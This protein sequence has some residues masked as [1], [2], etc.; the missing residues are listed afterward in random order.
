[1]KT[2]IIS[3]ALATLI[4][5][6]GTNVWVA[7][8][9]IHAKSYLTLENIEAHAEGNN[10]A[11]I[12][13]AIIVAGVIKTVADLAIIGTFVYSIC[14]TETA[15][16]VEGSSTVYVGN[17]GKEHGTKNWDCLAPGKECTYNNHKSFSF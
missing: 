12:P 1:M 14:K 15:A 8:N 10:E 5:V 13:P 7:T 3:L 4:I 16:W 11:T 6:A 17:D 9:N 2:K